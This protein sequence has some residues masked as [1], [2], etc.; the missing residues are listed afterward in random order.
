LTESITQKLFIADL[1]ELFKPLSLIP[2]DPL[3]KMVGNLLQTVDEFLDLL[4][5]VHNT[6]LGEAYQIMDTLRLMDFL[7]DM[8]KEDMFIRYVHQ[9]VNVQLSSNNPVEAALSLKLH[10]DLYTWNFNE[11]VPALQDPKFPEQTSFER[12]EQLFLEMISY[13]EDGKSWENALD[14]Y[15]ELA[16]NYER[17][18]FE[19]SKLARCYRAMANLQEAIME[20]NRVEPRFYRV[21]YYGLGFPIGLQDKQFI[22]QAGPWEGPQMFAD[23][24]LM[25][26]PAATLVNEVVDSVEGQFIQIVPVTPEMNFAGPAFRKQRVPATVREYLAKKGVRAFSLIQPEQP[27]NLMNVW[28]EKTVFVTA[29]GFPAILK[30]SEV[31]DSV[32]VGVSP[33]EKAIDDILRRTKELA[34]LE[35]TFSECKSPDKNLDMGR[36]SIAITNAVDANK[37]V[38]NHRNLLEEHETKEEVREALRTVLADHV[39]MVKKAL[40]THGR[41][42]PDALRGVQA[43]CAKCFEMTFRKELS[44]AMPAAPLP[45]SPGQWRSPLQLTFGSG[46]IASG[47]R[48]SDERDNQVTPVPLSVSTAN[49]SIATLPTASVTPLHPPPPPPQLAPDG[50]R[51]EDATSAIV[52]ENTRGRLTSMIFGS[53]KTNSSTMVVHQVPMHHRPPPPPPESVVSSTGTR[54]RSGSVSTSRS[55][56]KSVKSGKVGRG[57]SIDTSRSYMGQSNGRLVA[58][59]IA[60]SIATTED[61]D[62]MVDG[63]GGAGGGPGGKM[64]KLGG[65]GGGPSRSVVGSVRKRWSQLQ[66][67]KKNSK[68]SMKSSSNGTSPTNGAGLDWDGFSGG[69]GG[70]T[71]RGGTNRS[72]VGSD[73]GSVAETE[74]ED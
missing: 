39:A 19:Y 67:G 62:E 29:S 36:F 45:S 64:G 20:G 50:A 70:L 65:G 46:S 40:G 49:R 72:R 30:R 25:Q 48:R 24:M 74:D 58:P 12:R 53:N 6:P 61:E 5:A 68:G 47:S 33:V 38:A 23:R 73:F 13:F 17:T 44:E 34:D 32:V 8:R 2:Q 69:G 18:V 4:V 35:K 71:V 21:A 22:V 55:R 27:E 16:E 41:L 37:S 56:S 7:K 43:N 66:L 9:L 52:V 10:A 28:T 31:V 1:I 15:R 11:R 59:T 14:T 60:R 51:S 63:G 42:V 57:G 3:S 54:S 26:H